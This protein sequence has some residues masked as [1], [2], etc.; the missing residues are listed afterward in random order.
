MRKR[1][2]NR[3]DRFKPDADLNKNI[4]Q[5]LTHEK[6]RILYNCLADISNFM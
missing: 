4:K 1:I 2:F 6:N 3:N 5:L